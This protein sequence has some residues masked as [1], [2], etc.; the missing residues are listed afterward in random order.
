MP[1]VSDKTNQK[2]LIEILNE[3]HQKLVDS[4]PAFETHRKRM[5]QMRKNFDKKRNHE[6][7]QSTSD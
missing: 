3:S 6:P 4:D 2:D 7:K 5:E 1:K